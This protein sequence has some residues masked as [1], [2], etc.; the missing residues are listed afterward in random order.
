MSHE[1]SYWDEA[2][3]L[4]LTYNEESCPESLNKTHPQKF[5]RA[6]RAHLRRKVNGCRKISYYAVGEYGDTFGRPH[7]HAIVF[8]FDPRETEKLLRNNNLRPDSQY[9]K[10]WRDE[11]TGQPRGNI[12]VGDVNNKSIG[13][14]AKYVRK[15]LMGEDNTAFYEAVGLEP[16][17]SLTSQKP[18][19]GYRYYRDHLKKGGV[20]HELTFYHAGRRVNW[21]KY[22]KRKLAETAVK[23]PTMETA[24]S[25]GAYQVQKEKWLISKALRLEWKRKRQ[26][27][28]R[29][30]QDNIKSA[31]TDGALAN[32]A[33]IDNQR[34][35]VGKARELYLETKIKIMGG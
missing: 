21:P 6:L 28:I 35:A 33:T 34:I 31:I 26:L 20:Q 25:R 10:Y 32:N 2:S 12:N 9:A 7:Y 30:A 22:Y 14:C 17:F 11:R 5:F 4:T 23:Q 29:V 16:E 8:G 18:A 24:T 19:I 15:K 3:F 1:L 27:A 13:Y